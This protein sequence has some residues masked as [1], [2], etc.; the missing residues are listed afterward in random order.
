M[1]SAARVSAGIVVLAACLAAAPISTGLQDARRAGPVAGVRTAIGHGDL[2]AARSAAATGTGAEAELAR[3]LVDLF[4]GREA[5]ARARL[6]PLAQANAL[7]E[8]A[9]E[10]GLLELRQVRRDEANRWLNPLAA[11]RQFSG[12]DDYL[13][14]ARAARGIRQ[15]LL[16]GDAFQ[17]VAEVPRADIQAEWGD[18]WLADHQPAEAMVNHRAALEADPRWVPALLGVSRALADSEPDAAEAALEEAFSIAP[19]HPG[20]W[21]LAAERRL[22][23]EDYKGALEALD[24]VAA[25][26][27]GSIEEAALRAAIAYADRRTADVEPAI[28]A[29]AAIYPNSALALRLVGQE[30][31]RDYRF[32]EAAG[33]AQRA[34][35]LDAEDADAQGE[36]GLYLL[37]TGH[38]TGAR[39][40]LDWAWN[41]DKSN[42]LTKNLLDMLDKVEQ[43]TVIE[44]GDLIFKFDPKEAPVLKPYALPLGQAAY[45]EFVTRYGFTPKGPILIEVFPV[46]DDFAVRTLG[47]PG[48]VGA[49]GACFGRVIAMDSPQARQP[50]GSFSW[51]A[52]LWHE[53]AHVF[54]LQLSDYRVPRWLT[55]GI[56]GYEEHRKRPAWGR[57][58]NL[59]FAHVLAQGKTFGVKKLP[60]AF[61][62]PETLSLGY[63][64]ASL[65]VE[66]LVQ[67]NGDE[68]LRRLLRAYADGATDDEAFAKAFGRTLD[69]AEASFKQ[70]VEQRYGALSRAMAQPASNVAPDD[71]PALQ[72][73]AE[74]EPGNFRSQLAYGEALV[75]A[76]DLER[77]AQPLER[78]AELAPQAMGSGSP[79]MLLAQIFEK[80]GDAERARRE[81]RLLLEHDHTN[82]PAAR[83]LA[84]LS[85]EPG[86]MENLEF[87][88]RLM[89]DLYPFDSD[90][91]G[92]LGRLLA[93][94]EQYADALIEFEVALALGPANLAEAYVDAGEVLLKL[95]RTDEARQ[96]A[97]A[98][99]KI[100]PSYTRAQDLL[101]AIR[102]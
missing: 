97:V 49:L 39:T 40:A 89:A 70:F 60:E 79:R 77:A 66:H 32:D 4:V 50:P 100:A 31:A 64:E 63:F 72:A 43:F 101:L 22:A 8:A 94:R 76:G 83:Q 102:K 12:P 82:L 58:L 87:A 85:Q 14:L 84:A 38:E 7:G 25:V 71:L 92:R 34:V 29:A 19:D 78:A 30:A 65:V 6:T 5:E 10:L 37:R 13:R 28:A 33:Y 57:E 95:G 47:L 2:A 74:A 1:Q 99:M 75:R 46:H 21:L 42:P 20:A 36:L 52:T 41:L 11:V 61:K 23:D 62:R 16:A 15:K 73:R 35:D 55:E 17:R 68:G 93:G 69:D 91:H 67:Q 53:M 90:P 48:L 44:Q 98:A 51:H 9:L 45:D 26:R 3:A 27:T 80:R 96:Q 81:L 56:S 54:T 88:L 86:R 18:L 24:R 59:E